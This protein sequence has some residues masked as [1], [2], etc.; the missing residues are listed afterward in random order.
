MAAHHPPET[1]AAVTAALLTGM[2]TSEIAKTYKVPKQTV[3]RWR[4]ELNGTDDGTKTGRLAWL[5]A[6]KGE[7]RAELE[8]LV[9][10]YLY[11]Q[12]VL[13]AWLT[14][15]DHLS[16][17]EPERIAAIVGAHDSL[18]ARV[19]GLAERLSAYQVH[20][21]APAKPLEAGSRTPSTD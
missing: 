4:D 15:P 2:G 10:E 20:E 17:A 12:R 13:V 14:F 1:K 8:A 18:G 11:G 9:H 7:P 16:S 19:A 3:D 6:P 21:L 5:P